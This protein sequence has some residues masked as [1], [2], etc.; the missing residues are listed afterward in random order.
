VTGDSP[1]FEVAGDEGAAEE[2]ELSLHAWLLACWGMPIGE[3]FDPER[4]SV[5]YG[6]RK[7]YSFFV[8]G[9]P[10]KVGFRG[11]VT[12]VVGRVR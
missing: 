3:M 1:A 9:V 6:R 8:G 7:K 12:E 11:G 10:L 5:E 2:A 4:L